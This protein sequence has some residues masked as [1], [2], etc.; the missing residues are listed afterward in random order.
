MPFIYGLANLLTKIPNTVVRVVDVLHTFEKPM[1]D[2]KFFNENL[3]AVFAAMSEDVKNRKET[4][5]LAFNIIVGAASIDSVLDSVGKDFAEAAFNGQLS[6]KQNIYIIID[7]YKRFK[8]LKLKSW[9]S[10]VNAS[11]GLWLGAG[12]DSQSL[13]LTNSL[14]EEDKKYNYEGMAYIISNGNYTLIKTMMDG[15]D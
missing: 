11:N 12:L 4:Q 5:P 9:Y 7:D 8:Q 1:L 10:A 14:T 13:L 15:D 6:S 3:S 2:I